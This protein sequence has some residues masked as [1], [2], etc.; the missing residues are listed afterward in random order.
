MKENKHRPRAR[1]MASNAA[2]ARAGHDLAAFCP[3]PPPGAG[4]GAES[5]VHWA[6][7]YRGCERADV[8]RHV[9][10]EE[11][12]GVAVGDGWPPN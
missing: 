3:P 7:R 4:A 6:K 1:A 10:P 11:R 8:D 2:R 12:D 9:H 5:Q